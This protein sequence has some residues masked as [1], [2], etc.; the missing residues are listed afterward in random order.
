MALIFDSE[1]IEISITVLLKIA[2]RRVALQVD[3][4]IGGREVVIKALGRQLRHVPAVSAAELSPASHQN[5]I[6]QS[7][8]A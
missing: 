1:F 5:P 4:L 3:Q 2:G 8:A 7:L 6:S